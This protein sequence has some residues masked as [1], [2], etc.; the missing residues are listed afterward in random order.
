MNNQ[1]M[2]QTKRLCIQTPYAMTILAS[3]VL[4]F[5]IQPLV[6][7]QMLP[8]FGGS[9]EL[10]T[11]S[12]FFFQFML[13]A[14]YFYTYLLTRHCLP[15]V[16]TTIH[17]TL[18]ILALLLLPTSLSS[19]AEN[20]PDTQPVYTILYILFISIG[21]PFFLLCT[22]APLIQYWYNISISGYSTYRLY[23]L[24][25]IGAL[26][27]LLSYPLLIEP[28][29]SL[30]LQQATWSYGFVLFALFSAFSAIQ[31]WLHS[32][33]TEK[34]TAIVSTNLISTPT[35][36]QRLLWFIL[37][38]VGT[39]MLLTITNHICREIAVVPLLW[40]LPLALYL[41][42]FVLG[43]DHPRWYRRRPY[44][45][46]FI[47]AIIVLA[48]MLN[49][50]FAID[51]WPDNMNER[52]IP[53]A[54][55]IAIYLF[56]FFVIVMTCHGELARSKPHPQLLTT[57]YLSIAS[58]GAFG[59][60]FVAIIAPLIFSSY[61]ELQIGIF[62][63]CVFVFMAWYQDH[64]SPLFNKRKGLFRSIMA[65]AIL[66]FS[67]PLINSASSIYRNSV[68]VSRN[69]YGVIQVQEHLQT[70]NKNHQLILKQAGIIEGLQFTSSQ[71][72]SLATAY[73]APDSGVG[74]A[75]HVLSSRESLRVGA[76]GL[77]VGTIA[78]Y[79]REQDYFRF[80]EL[81]PEVSRIADKY[82]T[83][84]KNSPSKIDILPGDARLSMQNED[85]QQFDLIV[86]DAFR[87][88]AIPTHLLSVEAFNL[89]LQHL[90][91]GG[92]LALH[93]SNNSL[94]FTPLVWNIAQ[95]FELSSAW[96][97]NNDDPD[98]GII[99]S[100]WFLLTNNH[101]F[102]S[103]P[104]V[105]SVSAINEAIFNEWYDWKHDKEHYEEY[106]TTGSKQH[107]QRFIEETRQYFERIALWT[108][109]YSNILPMLY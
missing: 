100:E 89:Y 18:L 1:L 27:A 20:I 75:L 104:E 24:S 6:S 34:Q 5:L 101:R 88:D 93:T 33:Q 83:Y 28:A 11:T 54:F 48:I 65:T 19:Y 47:T 73:Y 60:L 52:V 55:E 2:T 96:F 39:I 109:D 92:V 13:L 102:L 63:S 32:R 10:W 86:L 17:I 91:P 21:L 51:S 107:E 71:L 99:G 87:G 14:G 40:I 49:N 16:Q 105:T 84:L 90:A 70:V 9:H 59:G 62:L 7:K 77:G 66:L 37:P 25:N 58:G 53:I 82:F 42:T 38:A 106:L 79:G 67:W 3:T 36:T 30:S 41:L 50:P 74:I 31:Q 45:V 29:M 12:M 56:F 57:Y 108:D 94:D 15:L 4:M 85:P 98:L 72:E 22:T 95:H 76:I 81:N 44:G 43:F 103:R 23:A 26:I 68:E 61:L 8:W 69:F 35:N 46:A 78:S 64:H 97:E 80:Y